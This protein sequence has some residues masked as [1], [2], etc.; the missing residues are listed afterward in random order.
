M[1]KI[2]K[3]YKKIISIK[4]KK[5]MSLVIAV[6]TMTLLLSISLSV[7]NI[8]L[9]Q[10][11][12]NALTNNS[13]PAFFV[14]DSAIECA[15]YYDTVSMMDDEGLIDLNKEF[16]TSF[17]GTTTDNDTVFYE[18]LLKCGNGVKFISKVFEN[19]NSVSNTSFDIDYGDYCAKVI[20]RKDEANSRITARGYN[21]KMGETSCDLSNLDSRRVVERGL[22]IRY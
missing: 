10:I 2:Y 18:G 22:T 17:F 1:L 21:T 6:M 20:V 13:K 3:K 16:T 7:S 12:L 15:F 8:V 11:K 19:D 5:G 4:D 9:R 14:A